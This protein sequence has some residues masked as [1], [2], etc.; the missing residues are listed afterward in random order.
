MAKK[1]KDNYKIIY[2][3]VDDPNG[4]QKIDMLFNMLFETIYGD[5]KGKIV[6]TEDDNKL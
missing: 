1:V 6:L 4:Q 3:Q 2:E 5:Y